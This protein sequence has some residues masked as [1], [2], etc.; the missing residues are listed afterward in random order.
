MAGYKL[1]V[2]NRKGETIQEF[3]QSFDGTIT[4]DQ[5]KKQFLKDNE[6]ARNYTTL[7]LLHLYKHCIP[8]YLNNLMC[9]Y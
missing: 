9:F 2:V 4:V 3:N 7:P 1:V 8:S 6:S 5:F